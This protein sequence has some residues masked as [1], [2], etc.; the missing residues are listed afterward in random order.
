[1]KIKINL[2]RF[3][4]TLLVCLS[5]WHCASGSD[6]K[7]AGTVTVLSPL[8]QLDY[9]FKKNG[10]APTY[11]FSADLFTQ[12]ATVQSAKLLVLVEGTEGLVLIPEGRK[13]PEIVCA[14]KDNG[15]GL[16]QCKDSFVLLGFEPYTLVPISLVLELKTGQ[17]FSYFKSYLLPVWQKKD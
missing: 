4:S 13:T 16:L 1:M 7:P 3:F 15:K 10:K 14:F 12:E 17:R 8:L 2:S 6:S 11:Q 5:C 9:S